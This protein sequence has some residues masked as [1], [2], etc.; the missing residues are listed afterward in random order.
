MELARLRG[1]RVIAQVAP[2]DERLVRG[3]GAE[4]VV[5]RG[6]P[7]APAVRALIP[8]GV[9][10]VLDAANVGVAAMDAVRHGGAF[11]ALLDNAP[12]ARRGIRSVNV[13]W[14]VDGGRLAEL[15]A[16]AEAGRL[17]L[18]VAATYPLE[19]AA[20]AHEAVDR[21]GSRGRHVLVP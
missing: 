1:L 2:A 10:G 12:M 14:T 17:T 20:E 7:L 9:D 3:F 18:R 19:Q 8:D 13:A 21:G 16:L 4:L 5:A 15:S 6:V 11:A